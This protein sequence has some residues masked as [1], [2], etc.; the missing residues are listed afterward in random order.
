MKLIKPKKRITVQSAKAKGRNLQKWVCKKISELTGHEWGA[1]CPISSR[2]MGQSGTDVRLESHVQ[3]I[4]PYSVECKA[5]EAWS[6]MAW[7]EQAKKNTKDGTDWLLVCKR[8]NLSP[9]IVIDAEK[10]FNLLTLLIK[11]KN[12]GQSNI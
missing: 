7:I 2:P 6:V 1:D 11:E 5:Q 8:K 9:V 10:F 3:K 4:F 12:D